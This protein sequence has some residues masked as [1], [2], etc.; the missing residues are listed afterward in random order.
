MSGPDLPSD[1]HRRLPYGERVPADPL[2]GGPFFPFEG[3]IQVGPA[4]RTGAPGTTPR[5]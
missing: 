1:Y 4:G 2:L 5:R 3:D